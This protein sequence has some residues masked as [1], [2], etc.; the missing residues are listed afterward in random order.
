MHV[1]GMYISIP[2]LAVAEGKAGGDDLSICPMRGCILGT[3]GDIIKVSC[4][5]GWWY[6]L[7]LCI[8]AWCIEGVVHH[9]LEMACGG[10]EAPLHALSDIEAILSDK[11]CVG[12][13][14]GWHLHILKT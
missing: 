10:V 2:L 9:F 7:A 1:S 5:G 14:F 11:P 4:M 12:L 8:C 13:E 6:C 3:S